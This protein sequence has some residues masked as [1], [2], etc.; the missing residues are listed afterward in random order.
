MGWSIK[1][2]FGSKKSI[3]NQVLTP[4]K[5]A[6]TI[7][8]L[9]AVSAVAPK[10]AASINEKMNL[11]GKEELNDATVAAKI[12]GP[13]LG[14]AVLGA[15]VASS[16]TAAS[17]AEAAKK[18][19]ELKDK[20]EA[21]AKKLKESEAAKMLEDAAKKNA[22]LQAAAKAAAQ[23]PEEAIAA[24]VFKAPE[25][26]HDAIGPAAIKTA[27]QNAEPAT[28]ARATATDPITAFFNWVFSIIGL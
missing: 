14:G 9:A 20:A 1:K 26:G 21:E 10:A 19:Q 24:Q 27:A 22:E 17:V 18:A 6:V 12:V 8:P 3:F 16:A 2:P 25:D 5:A 23:K 4:V 15:V 13:I 28:D 11:V 7:V